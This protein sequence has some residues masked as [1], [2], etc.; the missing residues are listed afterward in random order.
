MDI[1]L[2]GKWEQHIRC[3]KCDFPNMNINMNSESDL[4]FTLDSK[5]ELNVA[6]QGKHIECLMCGANIQDICFIGEQDIRDLLY[7]ALNGKSVYT[8]GE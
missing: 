3:P 8:E 1:N 6:I 2:Q 4:T 7:R 5:N